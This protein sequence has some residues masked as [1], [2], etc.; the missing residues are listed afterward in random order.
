MAARRVISE[1]FSVLLPEGWAEVIDEGTFSDP[2]EMPPM[3][4]AREAGTGALYVVPVLFH[5]ENQPSDTPD[6]VEALAFEWGARRGQARP[7][8][9]SAE[10]RD[11]GCLAT[12][13]FHIGGE[14]VQVWFLSDGHAV[15]RACYVCPWSARDNE[16]AARHEVVSSLTFA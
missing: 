15:L 6:A 9:C 5:A 4:F 12:A 7:L 8:A 16:R 13:S 2:D 11:D 3:T 14:F 1:G 10:R